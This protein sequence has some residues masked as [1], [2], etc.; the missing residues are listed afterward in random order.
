MNPKQNKRSRTRKVISHPLSRIFTAEHYEQPNKQELTVIFYECYLHNRFY[1]PRIEWDIPKNILRFYNNRSKKEI[2][3]MKISV[4]NCDREQQKIDPI[5]Q[6]FFMIKC[7]VFA[8][9]MLYNRD[10]IKH[11][12]YREFLH[13]ENKTVMF[14]GEHHF[15]DSKRINRFVEFMMKFFD[16]FKKIPG[17][18]ID[19]FVEIP[20]NVHELNYKSK[21][22]G[23]YSELFVNLKDSS[24]VRIH[25]IDYRGAPN[26]QHFQ[27]FCFYIIDLHEN[28]MLQDINFHVMQTY[29]QN[30]LPLLNISDFKLNFPLLLKQY[31]KIK[32]VHVL[33]KLFMDFFDVPLRH[34][35]QLISDIASYWIAEQFG[36]V[37][38]KNET[39]KKYLTR[40]FANKI[41]SQPSY[42]LQ[43]GSRFMDIYTIGRMLKP[44][45]NY[46]IVYGGSFHTM[47]ILKTLEKYKLL[48]TKK[49]P[50]FEEITDILSID[51]YNLM[52]ENTV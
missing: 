20:Y 19:F 17:M 27:K 23:P 42:L 41:V 34:V 29:L 43:V 24:N 3:C 39:T 47:D 40:I 8:R 11:M 9:E 26:I 1:Y 32:K 18:I 31:Q 22:G 13:D 15:L 48:S 2:K 37:K 12:A 28:G 38:K 44:G 50:E 7:R 21:I 25:K 14:L 51:G 30:I 16:S 6:D 36:D 45:Y 10:E 5:E 4:E 33:R 52:D 35:N 49:D 46:C